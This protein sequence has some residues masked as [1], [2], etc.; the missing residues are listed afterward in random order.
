MHNGRLNPAEFPAS[1][2]LDL[3]Q[4]LGIPAIA[5]ATSLEVLCCNAAFLRLHAII[6]DVVTGLP[7]LELL[8]SLLGSELHAALSRPISQGGRIE[9]PGSVAT[10]FLDSLIISYSTGKL[11]LHLDRGERRRLDEEHWQLIDSLAH[12]MRTPLS[13]IRGYAETLL[14][15][16]PVSTA[17]N[18]EYLESILRL[19]GNL[20]RIVSD[21]LYLSRL[22]RSGFPEPVG[23]VDMVHMLQEIVDSRE[24]AAMRAGVSLEL[25]IASGVPPVQANRPA[26]H[27]I[28]YNLLDNAIKYM[29]AGGRV[30]ISLSHA[31][32]ML[33]LTISD[34]GI[35]IPLDEQPRI[36]ERFFRASQV[37]SG[38]YQGAGLGLS[39][40]HSVVKALGGS[41][42]V[43]S[44]VGEGSS[45]MV[46]LPAG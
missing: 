35:G 26:V 4:P 2:L 12:A 14:L 22:E 28:I 38:D 32:D 41:I 24:E 10:H 8:P 40:V 33:E 30:Q 17:K 9:V 7:L 13:S 45:F 3:C 43:D 23:P 1:Q 21:L 44:R 15:A 11:L 46:K 37:R 36:F 19:S 20:N 6:P 5:L 39:K 34:C 31:G 42:R 25:V 16:Q 29:P 27:E 18:E